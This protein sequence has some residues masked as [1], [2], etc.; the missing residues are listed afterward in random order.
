LSPTGNTS[1]TRRG[2]L[3]VRLAELN[4][5]SAVVW[6]TGPAALEAVTGMAPSRLI[7][8]LGGGATAEVLARLLPVVD[9]PDAPDRVAEVSGAELVRAPRVV[10]VTSFGDDAAGGVMLDL[11]RRGPELIVVDGTDLALRDAIRGIADLNG[12]PPV[13]AVAEDSRFR[14]EDGRVFCSDEPL[15][16]LGPADGPALCVALAVLDGIGVDVPG[17]RETLR[18]AL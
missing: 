4:G 5:R 7:A 17:D 9:L 6:S 11:L 2:G 18:S 13:P 8:V 14:V 10:V 1:S 3:D 15:F 16:P 12:F